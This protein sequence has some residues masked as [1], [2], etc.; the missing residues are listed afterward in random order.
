MP[1]Q[2]FLYITLCSGLFDYFFFFLLSIVAKGLFLNWSAHVLK[3]TDLTVD[4]CM[5]QQ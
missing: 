3:M 4:I 5:Y 1:S 2:I